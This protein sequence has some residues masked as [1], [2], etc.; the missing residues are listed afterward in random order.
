MGVYLNRADVKAA[1]GAPQDVVWESCSAEV[2]KY[3]AGDVMKVREV[4]LLTFAG[5]L[6]HWGLI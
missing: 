1:L 4:F 3:L 6:G 5:G 2:D